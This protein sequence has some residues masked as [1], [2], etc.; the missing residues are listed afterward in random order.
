MG[1]Q[2]RPKPSVIY[3][4]DGVISK[5]KLENPAGSWNNVGDITSSPL[6]DKGAFE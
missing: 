5:K 3:S 1:I 6:Q 4:P 2:A